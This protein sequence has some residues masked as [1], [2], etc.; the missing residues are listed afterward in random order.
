MQVESGIPYF[1][2]RRELWLNGKKKKPRSDQ[3]PASITKFEEMVR[4]PGAL[5]SN[6][7]WDTGLGKVSKRLMEGGRLKYNLPM[8][9]LVRMQHRAFSSCPT[10]SRIFTDKSTVRW[11]DSRW[12]VAVRLPCTR[13]RGCLC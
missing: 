5:R 12:G 11:M 6:T 1:D 7:V 10:R 2:A 3:I 13:V 9:L 4:D 8:H